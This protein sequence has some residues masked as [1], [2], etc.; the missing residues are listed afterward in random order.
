M[1]KKNNPY[2]DVSDYCYWSRAVMRVAPGLL[3]PVTKSMNIDQR[4]K[5]ATMG[6]CFAQH[7]SRYL[8]NHGFNFYIAEAPSKAL[9]P[10]EIRTL[11]YN[12]YSAR[13]GNIY[14]VKQAVQLFDRAY[15]HF[16]PVDDA[17]AFGDKWVDAFRPTISP[18]GFNSIDDVRAEAEKHLRFV[19]DV[20]EQS[21]WLIFTLGLTEGWASRIDNAI[22]PVAPGVSS[23]EYDPEKYKF[24]NFTAAEVSDDLNQFIIKLT[25]VN[26]QVKIILTVSPVPLI[27]T[28]EDRH[29]LVSTTYSKS[30]LCVAAHEAENA[31]KNVTYFPSYDLITSPAIQGNYFNNDLRTITP[32]GVDHAMRLFEKH[33]LNTSFPDNLQDTNPA[34]LANEEDVLCDEELIELIAKENKK[35][36]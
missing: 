31:F 19:R 6:S 34:S 4:D 12:V 15:G 32:T 7:I 5:I 16:T 36:L 35:Q 17:W 33:F 20:F 30:V 11:N 28:Y 23:G 22:Y 10:E 27:A 25:E 2:S 24:I 9:S 13:Y 26:P 3:D 18:Y 29:V 21:D 8:A 14:T 1:S